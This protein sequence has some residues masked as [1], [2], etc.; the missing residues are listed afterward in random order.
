MTKTRSRN[1]PAAFTLI[2][3]LVII[4]IIAI[5]PAILFPVFTQSREK[6][7][8]SA[9]LSGLRQV[10]LA[11]AQYVQDY[12]ETGTQI[13]YGPNSTNQRYFWMDALLP[14]VKSA[15]FFSSCPSAEYP[16]VWKPSE[17]IEVPNANNGSRVNVSFTANSLYAANNAAAL[18]ADK[19]PTTPP[20]RE[21]GI[22]YSEYVVPADTILFGDGPGY[23]ICYSGNKDET[24]VELTAP[25]NVPPPNRPVPNV[26]RGNDRNARFLARHQEGANFAFCD[27][28]AKWL[29]LDQATKTNGNG[30][31][32]RFTVEDD[33]NL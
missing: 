2:E 24:V 13:W 18:A 3:M 6:A 4:A 25:Y 15:D 11:F 16:A 27:G 31:M 22:P 32:H 28:H 1:T 26:G 21:A 29:R 30:I 33:A 10:G 14:Y 23:Y 7:R 5:L 17:R 8:Q 12:D 19:Q 9:C 20:M